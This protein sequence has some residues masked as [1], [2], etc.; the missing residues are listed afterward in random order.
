MNNEIIDIKAI[1]YHLYSE[2]LRDEDPLYIIANKYINIW[3]KN[4]R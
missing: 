1:Y 2:G 3:W 4:G